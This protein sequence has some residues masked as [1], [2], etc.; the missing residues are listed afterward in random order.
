M[1]TI[2]GIAV[3][4][5][6]RTQ[7]DLAAVVPPRGVERALGQ[8]EV[9]GQ[10]DLDALLDQLQRNARHPGAGRLRAALGRDDI[11]ATI[12]DSA[13]EERFLAFC[14]AHGFPAPEWHAAID[15]GDGGVLLRPD[16]VWRD[17]RVALELDGERFHRTRAAFHTDRTRDQRLVAAG[18]R[19]IR[20]TWDQL[21]RRP[22]ELAAV[23]WRV[24]G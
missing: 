10:F 11:G 4:T 15:P 1:T 6:A 20:A 24:L 18:W 22:Q 3:T 7:L 12:T 19:V 9:L 23:L 16:A 2:D 17:Q 5:V 13:L 21:T 14:R 8:A